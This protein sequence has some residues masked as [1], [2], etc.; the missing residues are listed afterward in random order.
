MKVIREVICSKCGKKQ[1]NDVKDLWQSDLF[2]RV[3]EFCNQYGLQ[4]TIRHKLTI[5]EWMEALYNTMGFRVV[6]FEAFI[7]DMLKD[8]PRL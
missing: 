1:V 6:Q 4:R 2:W 5:R 8:R 3:C 7:K